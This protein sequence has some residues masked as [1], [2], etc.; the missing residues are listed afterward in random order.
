M[1]KSACLAA[2]LSVTLPVTAFGQTSLQFASVEREIRRE[3]AKIQRL[4]NTWPRVERKYTAAASRYQAASRLVR[5]CQRGTWSVFFKDIFKELDSARK[6]LEEA[7]A[8]L[9]AANKSATN[10]M[11][12]QNRSLRILEASYEGRVR[13]AAYWEKMNTVVDNLT[14]NYADILTEVVVPGYDKY[15][16]GIDEISESYT[17]SAKDCNSALPLTPLRNLFKSVLSIVVGKISVA[18]TL[19]DEILELVPDKFKKT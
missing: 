12:S 7:R 19:A 18:N 1:F 2:L 11:R 5:Q 4:E 15:V 8:A 9:N 16:E 3:L 6:K 10:A 17:Y 14:A 13:D